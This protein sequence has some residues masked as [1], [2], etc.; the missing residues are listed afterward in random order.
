MQIGIT[1]PIIIPEEGLLKERLNLWFNE[2]GIKPNIYAEVK[3][4]EAIVSMVSLG[5]ACFAQNS[6]R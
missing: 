5:L 1:F 6:G 3:G 4:N 2:Q